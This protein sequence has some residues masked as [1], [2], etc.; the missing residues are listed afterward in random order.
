MCKM[1]ILK[2]VATCIIY[3]CINNVIW[4][5]GDD[6]WTKFKKNQFPLTTRDGIFN[7]R[8]DYILRGRILQVLKLKNWRDWSTSLLVGIGAGLI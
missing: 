6:N 1:D 4:I 2:G 8:S 7:N 5:T 3:S